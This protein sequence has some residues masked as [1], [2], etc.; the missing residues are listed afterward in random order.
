[1][2]NYEVF[3]NVFL[4]KETLPKNKEEFLKKIYKYYMIG[5]DNREEE[6]TRTVNINFKNLINQ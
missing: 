2:I 1:M 5:R 4:K 6:I 3:K